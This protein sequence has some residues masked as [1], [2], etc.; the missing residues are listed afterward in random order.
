MNQSNSSKKVL[1]LL[2]LLILL[3]NSLWPFGHSAPV[4]LPIKLPI[5]LLCNFLIN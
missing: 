3:I 5:K 4:K 1:P 2:A